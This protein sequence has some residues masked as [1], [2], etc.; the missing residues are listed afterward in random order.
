MIEPQSMQLGASAWVWKLTLVA[1]RLRVMV[2]L[3]VLPPLPLDVWPLPL[4]VWPLVR[5]PLVAMTASDSLAGTGVTVSAATAG[6]L[7]ASGSVVFAGSASTTGDSAGA[8]A[9]SAMEEIVEPGVPLPKV[10]GLGAALSS[11]TRSWRPRLIL[12]SGG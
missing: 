4:A 7:G 12:S 8:G 2:G 11:E 1:P 6:A 10:N 3:A 9:G 5:A